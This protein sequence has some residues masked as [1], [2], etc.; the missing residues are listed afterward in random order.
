MHTHYSGL[1]Y[2]RLTTDLFQIQPLDRISS[3]A[4]L[5]FDMS[6]LAFLSGPFA[7]ATSIV[8]PEAYTKMPASLSSLIEQE[9]MSIWYSVP[10]ALVQLLERGVLDQRKLGH[11]RWVLFG[12]E[13]FPAKP[14]RALMQLWPQA[15]F[16]NIYGPA[17][18]NQCTHY[19]IPEPPAEDSSIPLGEVWENTDYLILDAEDRV[20]LDDAIG[21]L[22]IRSATRM[23][24]YWNQA[25]R[26]ERSFFRYPQPTGQTDIYYRTGDLVQRNTEG[27]LLF[28]G[29]KDRQIKIRGYRVELGEIENTLLRHPAVRETAVYVQEEPSG[30]RVILAAVVL[31]TK[32]SESA[33]DILTWIEAQL[34]RYA[35]PQ[36]LTLLPALPRTSAGKINYRALVKPTIS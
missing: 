17:E 36:K 9:Q 20:I 2:A 29:R 31:A 14:L 23:A 19:H 6:T 8:I 11:L 10:L 26:T 24:G 30:K 3:H 25:E 18:V 32:Q 5:H 33:M 16:S 35:Q 13:P 4:Q 1:S 27:L 34:P 15:Q 12:G 22:V 28:I 7:G 21:E